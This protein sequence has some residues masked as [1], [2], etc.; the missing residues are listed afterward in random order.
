MK[1]FLAAAFILASTT[2]LANTDKIYNFQKLQNTMKT[3]GYSLDYVKKD[4]GFSFKKDISH[5]EV[6]GFKDYKA[7]TVALSE[8]INLMYKNGLQ[9]LPS[10]SDIGNGVYVFTYPGKPDYFGVIVADFDHN[11]ILDSYDKPVALKKNME[12]LK[13]AQLKK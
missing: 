9:M 6:V 8:M 3:E 4:V 13:N 12:H 10:E 1:K 2:I 11:V 5:V 7:T